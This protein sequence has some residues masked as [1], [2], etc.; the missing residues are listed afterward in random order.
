MVTAGGVDLSLYVLIYLISTHSIQPFTSYIHGGHRYCAA[1]H[2]FTIQYRIK[3]T[4]VH[5]GATTNLP[6][7]TITALVTVCI[8]AA[9]VKVSKD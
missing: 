5:T 2:I 7:L 4:H 1:M 3:P 9:T 6:I 8:A